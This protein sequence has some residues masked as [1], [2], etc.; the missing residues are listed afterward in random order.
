MLP[1]HFTVHIPAHLNSKPEM[2]SVLRQVIDKCGGYTVT[3]AR[4]AYLRQDDSGEIDFERINILTVYHG[5]RE[6]SAATSL[7]H[8]IVDLLHLYGEESVLVDYYGVVQGHRRG[9]IFGD[10]MR[11][12]W[13]DIDK[14]WYTV[15]NGKRAF[16]VDYDTASAAA[17]VYRNTTAASIANKE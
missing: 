11:V 3:E 16:Y 12:E 14:M 13:S 10:T 17:T 5:D 8:K 1:Y 7:R 15:V 2:L 9:L 6:Q 4:G